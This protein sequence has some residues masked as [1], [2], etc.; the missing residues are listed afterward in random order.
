MKIVFEPHGYEYVGK[1]NSYKGR[2]K[3][4]DQTALKR[5]QLKRLAAKPCYIEA[6]LNLIFSNLER[7]YWALFIDVMWGGY[8]LGEQLHQLIGVN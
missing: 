1:D 7:L 5:K 2:R 3:L 6:V 4:A 8:K